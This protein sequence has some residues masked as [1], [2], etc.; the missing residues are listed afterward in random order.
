MLDPDSAAL[1]DRVLTETQSGRL[2]W[3]QGADDY[4]TAEVGTNAS[5][6]YIRRMFIEATNQTGAD[7]YFVEISVAGWNA[8]FAITDDSDG[9]RAVR[10]ILNAAFP[11][12]WLPNPKVALAQLEL[13]LRQ[14]D[15]VPNGPE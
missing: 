10:E 11:N 5:K 8:R 2:K 13:K 3:K 6:I 15:G 12:G 7:P 4:F 9:W 1:L 14:Q